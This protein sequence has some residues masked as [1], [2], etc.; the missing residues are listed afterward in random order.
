MALSTTPQ[1]ETYLEGLVETLAVSDARYEQAE[2]SYKSLG[3]WL[4]RP[5]SSVRE[6]GPKVYIQGSFGLGT[7]I[8]PISD[9][10]DY[11]VDSVCEFEHLTS[12]HLTQKHL[13]ELLGAEIAAYHRAQN[14]TKPIRE[15]RRCWV[16]NYADGAQF[17]MD[18]V[19]ALP[20][21]TRQRV[22]LESRGLDAR[23][24]ATAIGITDNEHAAYEVLSNDWPRSNPK[25]YIQWFRSRM[26]VQFE[27]RRRILAEAAKA[28]V[29]DIP[30]YRV[31][32]PLQNAIMILKRHRDM[33]YEGDP[34]DKPISII[35]TTLAA[36][37]YNGEDNIGDALM[38][39]LSNM[40]S[41]I[42][43]QNG[44][45]L[46]PNPSDPTENFADKWEEFPERATTFFAWLE[47]ARADFTTIARA[48]QRERIIETAS[49]AVGE[50]VAKA[51]GTKG[52]GGSLRGASVAPVAAVAPTFPNEPRVP[53]SP[54]G[55]G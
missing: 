53:T 18:V 19:P 38:S 27:K 3:D 31:R 54:R 44:K 4:C 52:Y 34:C 7:T 50:R 20:N 8:R 46:I 13:K 21:G 32:T 51:A 48:V 15:G 5:E 41:A 12:S 47:Q 17:H 23:F 43:Y 55:F 6:Y 36:H 42:I 30:E 28:S 1:A 24:A 14:M 29:E 35:I 11:D 40:E 49:A 39:I 2:R 16:L 10:E 33:R 26:T 22:L 37:A 25:G 45:Y 9:E